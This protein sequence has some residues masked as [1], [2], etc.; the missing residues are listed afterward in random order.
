MSGGS[1]GGKLSKAVRETWPQIPETDL[2]NIGQG[3]ERD[4]LTL[5]GGRTD[6][7]AL[8]TPTTVPE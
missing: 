4:L 1:H 2:T 8:V 7:P 5:I 3:N 6:A